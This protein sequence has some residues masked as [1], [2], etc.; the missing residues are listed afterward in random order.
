V[1]R[2]LAAAML[3][4]AVAPAAAQPAVAPATP[5]APAPSPAPAPAPS[6]AP[7][8]DP[9]EPDPIKPDRRAVSEA[10]EANLEPESVREGLAFGVAF[11]PNMQVGFG[12]EK[13][14]GTGGSIAFRFGTVASPRWVWLLEVANTAYQES[15]VI[16]GDTVRKLNQSRL[17]TLGAQLY[18]SDAFWLRG[19]GGL[20]NFTRRIAANTPETSFWGAGVVGAGGLDVVRRRS[21]AV[22]LEVLTALARYRDGSVAAGTLQLGLSWY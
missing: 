9:D 13:S 3:L 8:D 1:T 21:L 11:G 6:P 22:S 7:T 17:F 4:A 14:T 18:L 10:R 12:I 5:P 16:D 15:A 2:A 20:A 19:G